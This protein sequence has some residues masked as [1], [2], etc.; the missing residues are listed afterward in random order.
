MSLRVVVT[1]GE[2][3]GRLPFAS[4][5]SE[6]DFS[7]V[8]MRAGVL[9]SMAAEQAEVLAFCRGIRS[10]EEVHRFLAEAGISEDVFHDLLELGFLASGP[11]ESAFSWLAGCVLL[12]TGRSLGFVDD[13]LMLITPQDGVLRVSPAYYWLWTY[14]RTGQTLAAIV[15]FL[16]ESLE[17]AEVVEA[18][19]EE[20]SQSVIHMLSFNL[21]RLDNTAD[22]G[23]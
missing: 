22:A 14:A 11:A 9:V 8:F 15:G 6:V 3:L 17:I 12:P 23:V 4:D 16:R 7:D 19:V 1:V 10:V 21:A 13:G 5:D 2:Y 18:S 20:L